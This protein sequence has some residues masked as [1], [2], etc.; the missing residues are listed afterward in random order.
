[1]EE[2]SDVRISPLAF[3]RPRG[4]RKTTLSESMMYLTGQIRTL[5]RVDHKDA[6]LDTHELEKTE[7]SPYFPN[8]RFLI[9]R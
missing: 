8:R 1:M 4:C 6:F 2:R 7:G 5:G 9:W 3:L